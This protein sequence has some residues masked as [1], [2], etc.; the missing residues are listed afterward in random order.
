MCDMKAMRKMRNCRLQAATWPAGAGP[1]DGEF[2][3][4]KIGVFCT[5]T[6]RVQAQQMVGLKGPLWLPGPHNVQPS[7]WLCLVIQP[8]LAWE[9]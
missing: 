3:L 6:L 4:E 9:S 5:G 8:G 1:A 7:V 2:K